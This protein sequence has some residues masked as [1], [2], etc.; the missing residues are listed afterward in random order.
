[1]SH[2]GDFW[3]LFVE[4]KNTGK[5]IILNIPRFLLGSIIRES[6]V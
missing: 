1:M 3:E 4:L 6:K 2:C 5:Y